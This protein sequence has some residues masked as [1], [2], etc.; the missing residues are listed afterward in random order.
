MALGSPPDTGASSIFT[1][2]SPQAAAI[3][4]DARGAM[5]L[6]STSTV[7]AWAPSSTPF[8]PMTTVLT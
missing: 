5:E 3:S 7:P 1:P 6:M 2:F 8:S 4:W